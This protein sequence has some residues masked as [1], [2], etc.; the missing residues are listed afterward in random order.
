MTVM[1]THFQMVDMHISVRSHKKEKSADAD[2]SLL[3]PTYL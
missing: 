1:A 2:F 3:K